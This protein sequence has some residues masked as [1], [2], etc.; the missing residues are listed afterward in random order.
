MLQFQGAA[1]EYLRLAEIDKRNCK[2]LRESSKKTLTLLW[3]T[4]EGNQ[5]AIDGVPHQLKK[6]QILC[7]T[8]FH[9]VES[10][11]ITQ[12]RMVRFNRAFYCILDH[13]P[14]VGC[15]G[16]LFFG[17]SQLPILDIPEAELEKFSI[18][19]QMFTMEFKSRDNLQIEMLQMMLKRLLIL[20]TRLHKEQHMGTQ[21]D[22]GTADLIRDFNFLVEQHF[23]TKHGVAEYA[24]LLHKSPKTLANYFSKYYDQSPIQII[25][26]RLMMEARRLLL[27]SDKAIKEIAYELGFDTLQAFSRFFKGKEGFS[28]KEFKVNAQK[29]I[30]DN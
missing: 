12:L 4:G 15:R 6:N 25:Q 3:F 17:A 19:W 11:A 13:D 1:Q 5:L 9:K 24:E 23:K 21:V 7:L 10:L 8:E 2:L 26:G 16:V 20:C 29:G 27:Y 14:Q 18:L 30:F 22:K 28:P